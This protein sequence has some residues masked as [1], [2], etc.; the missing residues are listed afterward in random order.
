MKI[1][2]AMLLIVLSCVGAFL[3]LCAAEEGAFELPIDRSPINRENPKYLTSYAPILKS[4]KEAVVAVHSASVVRFIRQRGM[5]PR[6]EMLRRY[7]GLPGRSQQAPEVEERRFSEGV[8]SGVVI[9]EDGYIITNSHVITSKDGDPADEILVQLNDGRELTASLVGRDP[10]SDVAVLKVEAEDLPFLPIA[11]SDQ[12]EVGDIVFAIGNPMGVGLTITQGIVSATGRDNLS[13]LGESGYESFIQ[14][15][16]PIN[17]GNSGG[18]LVDAYGRLIGINTAILSRSGGS[19]GIGFAIPSVFARSIALSLIRDGKVRRGVLGVNIT[20]LNAEYAEAFNVPE[21]EGVLVQSLIEAL[22]AELAGLQQGDV[23]LAIN[24]ESVSDV[25]DLRI[26][27]S[28]YPPGETIKVR[29]RREGELMEKDVVLADPEN[30]YGTG[31]LAGELL[32]G[33]EVAVLDEATRQTFGLEASVEGLVVVSVEEN[34]SYVES[35]EPGMV[36]LEINRVAPASVDQA[37]KLLAAR[38][39]SHLFVF[40]NGRTGYMPLR[41]N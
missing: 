31:A 18:A 5:D 40:L 35:F 2:I 15:D 39:V 41:A 22:P 24:D 16:A 38:R 13:I 11:D 32:E 8:G 14:T 4:A 6:E 9:S 21:G 19:I 36:I 33:V 1:Y 23:I 26:K 34:S 17:P 30:P 20:D 29:F 7:F 27:V 3:K 28:S 37:R 12:L 25:S 10:R